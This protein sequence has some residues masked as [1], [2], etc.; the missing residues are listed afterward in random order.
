MDDP[1]G[2]DID[3]GRQRARFTGDPHLDREAD[4]GD[5]VDEGAPSTQT[6]LRCEPGEVSFAVPL[7]PVVMAIVVAVG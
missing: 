7:G 1:A 4:E 3:A 5:P 6:R 2:G